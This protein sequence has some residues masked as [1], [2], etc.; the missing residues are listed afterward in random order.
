MKQNNL[1][2]Y[3]MIAVGAYAAYW[4][5]TNYGPNGAVV[6]ANGNPIPG[7]V[8]YWTSWFG[9]SASAATQIPTTTAAAQIPATTTTAVATQTSAPPATTSNGTVSTQLMAT[10]Q[11]IAAI[12]SYLLPSDLPAFQAMIPN[13]T[14]QQAAAMLANAQVCSNSFNP[15]TGSCYPPAMAPVDQPVTPITSMTG[16]ASTIARLL[17]ASGM[18]NSLSASQ[19]NYYY[20][21]LSGVP[22]TTGLGDNG[23]P[24]TVTQYLQLRQAAGLENLL[25]GNVQSSGLSGLGRMGQIMQLAPGITPATN[26]V[27]N[28]G[29]GLLTPTIK[30][31][32]STGGQGMG[33]LPPRSPW[34]KLPMSSYVN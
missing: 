16:D 30:S 7:A 24:M 4:Y 5:V 3:G 15:A 2:T 28:P 23:A 9:T 19:W 6:D 10:T 26:G 34:G 25:N 1:I 33:A 13:L 27:R 8:S 17:T 18:V 21:Q 32:P 31:V 20:T 29:M 12:Q 11:Q 22:Q 14:Y